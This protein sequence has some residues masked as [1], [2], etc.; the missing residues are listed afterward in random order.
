MD[1]TIS[2]G[3]R[4]GSQRDIGRRLSSGNAG[5]GACRGGGGGGDGWGAGDDDGRQ[6]DLPVS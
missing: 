2:L 1:T 5:S 3:S 6:K 4:S